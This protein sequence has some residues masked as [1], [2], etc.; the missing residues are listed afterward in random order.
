M[1]CLCRTASVSF[2]LSSAA[3]PRSLLVLI[4][5]V[6]AMGACAPNNRQGKTRTTAEACSRVAAAP[7]TIQR[8]SL[9]VRQ[10][11][12]SCI[13]E[14]ALQ[15]L[16]HFSPACRSTA[17]QTSAFRDAR[18]YTMP[19]FRGFYRLSFRRKVGLDQCSAFIVRSLQA[20][21]HRAEMDN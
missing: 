19:L 1:P 4:G 18:S 2:F 16:P 12:G 5:A 10:A 11:R 13:V 20:F 17:P 15:R 21:G 7:E 14:Q 9:R 6:A 8:S 3:T